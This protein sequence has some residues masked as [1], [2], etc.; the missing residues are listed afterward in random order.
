[1]HWLYCS[2]AQNHLYVNKWWVKCLLG[3]HSRIGR[4]PK[5]GMSKNIQIVQYQY[6]LIH[7]CGICIA[8]ALVILQ[9]CAKPL[10]CEQMMSEMSSRYTFPH[11]WNMGDPSYSHQNQH[12]EEFL[13]VIKVCKTKITW[14]CTNDIKIGELLWIKVRILSHFSYLASGKIPE[15]MQKPENSWSFTKLQTPTKKQYTPWKTRMRMADYR[16]D[17]NIRRTL[18]GN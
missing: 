15:I 18:I 8:D 4:N 6:R 7:H 11:S 14:N 5:V 16:Q 2:F 12:N 1:M 9:F 17:S 3:M 13:F 10:I